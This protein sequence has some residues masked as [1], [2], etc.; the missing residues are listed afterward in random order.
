[1]RQDLAAR[2]YV[3]LQN[4]SKDI[5]VRHHD[6]VPTQVLQSLLKS[7]IGFSI[8]KALKSYFLLNIFYCWKIEF[9]SW[10]LCWSKTSYIFINHPTD[11]EFL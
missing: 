10:K 6:R 11:L 2:K 4:F 7:Y 3:H 1:M 9:L 5:L 8:Y